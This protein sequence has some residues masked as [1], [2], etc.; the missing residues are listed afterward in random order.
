MSLNSNEDWVQKCP[1][2]SRIHVSEVLALNEI[3]W[4]ELKPTVWGW[5]QRLLSDFTGAG[6]VV[7]HGL[8]LLAPGRD[9]L[10]GPDS[11]E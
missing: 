3:S 4:L 7:Q 1:T 11:V 8:D 5:G 9:A 6:D 2:D 10:Q